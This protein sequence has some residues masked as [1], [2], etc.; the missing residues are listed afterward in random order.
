[1]TTFP[2]C[3]RCGVSTFLYKA[4]KNNSSCCRIDKY[5]FSS[6]LSCNCSG[7][8][9]LSN[10]QTTSKEDHQ[11]WKDILRSHFKNESKTFI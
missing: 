1:M 3:N 7:G 10:W 11:R 4:A 2:N 6:V 8:I 5:N 9:Y